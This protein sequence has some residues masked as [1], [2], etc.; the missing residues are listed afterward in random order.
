MTSREILYSERQA[1]AMEKQ[2]KAQGLI[3]KE[4]KHIREILG[5]MWIA[6]LLWVSGA[7]MTL[8]ADQI[9]DIIVAILRRGK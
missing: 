6:G 1:T 8:S 3:A 4:L 5:R 9:A 7:V 2:A